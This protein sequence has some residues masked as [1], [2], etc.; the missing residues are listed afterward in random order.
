MNS[1]IVHIKR[2]QSHWYTFNKDQVTRIRKTKQQL[3]PKLLIYASVSEEIVNVADETI[4]ES[5]VSLRTMEHDALDDETIPESK[6]IGIRS[7]ECLLISKPN[8]RNFGKG[9]IQYDKISRIEY[10]QN[11][12]SHFYGHAQIIKLTERENVQEMPIFIDKRPFNIEIVK[13]LG[14]GKLFISDIGSSTL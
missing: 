1:P 6:A 7:I 2:Y 3:S 10:E 9:S 13:I 5:D 14:D 11:L 12:F 4:S 8:Q